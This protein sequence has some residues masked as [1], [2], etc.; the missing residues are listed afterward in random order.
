MYFEEDKIWEGMV[1]LK[2]RVGALE[3]YKCLEKNHEKYGEML[4]VDI[5]QTRHGMHITLVI[6]RVPSRNIQ[7]LTLGY[8]QTI[9]HQIPRENGRRSEKPNNA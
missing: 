8:Y 4:P 9:K 7:L 2:M 1:G 3:A 5:P 6:C